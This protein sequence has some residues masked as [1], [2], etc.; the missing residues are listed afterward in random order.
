MTD[1]GRQTLNQFEILPM[2]TTGALVIIRLTV[3][4]AVVVVFAPHPI[5][6]IVGLGLGW[7]M[8]VCLA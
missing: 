4:L 1:A 2:N 6:R 5:D 7:G 3:A 8:V